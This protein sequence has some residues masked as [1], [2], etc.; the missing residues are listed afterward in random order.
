MKY[1]NCDKL[2]ELNHEQRN[3]L[4][5]KI[6]GMNLEH[7]EDLSMDKNIKFGTEIE[8]ISPIVKDIKYDIIKHF[9]IKLILKNN[10]YEK[11]K[12]NNKN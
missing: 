2:Y 8:F 5:N 3:I 7:R 4:F 1:F 12:K 9:N 11:D 10:T 6:S